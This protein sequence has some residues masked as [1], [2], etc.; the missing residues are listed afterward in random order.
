[1]AA[2]FFFFFMALNLVNGQSTVYP[3]CVMGGACGV[4]ETTLAGDLDAPCSRAVDPSAIQWNE[5]N[6]MED[7]EE[8]KENFRKLCPMLDIEGPLCCDHQQVV[9]MV[10]G[11]VEG[12]PKQ[13]LGACPSCFA[14]FAALY[15][16]MSCSP[17]QGNYISV[18]RDIPSKDPPYAGA[19]QV[20][21]V[22][23]TLHAD[24]PDRLYTS[25][26]DVSVAGLGPA[27]TVMGCDEGCN[28]PKLVAALGTTD[29]S[30]FQVDYTFDT[31]SSGSMNVPTFGCDSSPT[32]SFD[33]FPCSCS[34][35]SASCSKDPDDDCIDD[36]SS[37]QDV[38]ELVSETRILSGSSL[39]S[40]LVVMT[41]TAV[42][43]ITLLLVLLLPA[44]S[45]NVTQEPEAEEVSWFTS[46]RRSF[47]RSSPAEGNYNF[48]E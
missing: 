17:L 26:R 25:C 20:T 23:Y 4:V 40:R 27:L 16:A 33:S 38:Q 36:R 9:N 42:V 46:F 18:S 48:F 3:K 12:V 44:S 39:Q 11:I 21:A 14:N 45:S 28:G 29:R 31:S 19:R 22:N 8:V 15:C 37:D 7:G 32:G 47:R 2:L 24:W 5:N 13:L 10:N 30:P 34:D 41:V 35:C 43:I 1:M 6:D